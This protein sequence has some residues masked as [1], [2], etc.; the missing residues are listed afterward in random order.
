LPAI[1]PL[2]VE[3]FFFPDGEDS[4]DNG[5]EGPLKEANLPLITRVV[6]ERIKWFYLD[7]R[8]SFFKK[9]RSPE[10]MVY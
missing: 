2:L 3:V 4:G 6:A 1:E 8:P 7:M 9:A 5:M 10:L